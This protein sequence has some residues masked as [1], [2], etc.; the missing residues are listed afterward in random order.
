M[1]LNSPPAFLPLELGQHVGGQYPADDLHSPST[2][3]PTP[4]GED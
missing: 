2:A 3:T 4:D 1:A